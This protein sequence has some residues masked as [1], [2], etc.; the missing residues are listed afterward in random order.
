MEVATI[1]ENK[2]K[3]AIYGLM[4][5]INLSTNNKNISIINDYKF[6][7]TVKEHLNSVKDKNALKMVMLDESALKKQANELSSSEL[8]KVSFA[9]SLISN[10]EILVFDYFEKGLNHAEKENYKR[11]WKK[12]AEDFNKTILLYTNDL[13][14]L[15]GIASSIIYVDKDNAINTYEKKDYFKLLDIVDK[16]SISEFIESLRAKGIKID[17]YKNEQ[18]LLKAIYRLKAGEL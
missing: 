14:F 13:E 5:N 2:E 18:D 4:G 7:E 8:K 1:L 17:D 15:W 6:L 3:G 16:P 9:K 10:K 12:L 11:L